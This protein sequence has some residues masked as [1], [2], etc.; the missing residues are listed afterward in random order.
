MPTLFIPHG[1]GPCFFMKWDPPDTWERMAA[2]LRRMPTDVGRRP[3]A[4]AIISGHWEEETVT[5]QNNPSPPLLFDYYGFPE[6]TYQLE[7]PAPGSPA[8]AKRIAALMTEAGVSW[9]Y[10]TERGFDHGVFIPMKLAFPE[11]E[12]PIVQ[13]ALRA[14]LDPAAHIAFGEA[15]Q[16]LREE[17]I[18]I[19]GSGMT[20]HNM[21]TLTAN[22]RGGGGGTAPESQRFDDWLTDVLTAREPDDRRTALV[23]WQAAPVARMAHPREEHL[24]PLHVVVGA[25]G[26]DRGQRML[27]DKVL[28]A[29]ESAFQFG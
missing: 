2:Y 23:E 25:A 14:D 7:Y 17:G 29:V 21:Q 18:L 13:I 5:I 12:I 6:S 8:L 27:N 19:L 4:I 1:G 22:M 15:L 28:G 11:A 16:P 24:L 3:E 20:Y 9:K 26:S 10:D